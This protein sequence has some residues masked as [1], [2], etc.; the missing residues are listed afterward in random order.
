MGKRKER[1][2]AA[3][4][5]AGRRVKLDLCAEPPDLSGS[6]AHEEVGED[7]NAKLDTGSPKSP[8]SSGQEP[9]NPLLLLGQYSDEELDE[10]SSEGPVD[11]ERFVADKSIQ[12]KEHEEVTTSTVE[13]PPS[14]KVTEQDGGRVSCSGSPQVVEDIVEGENNAATAADIDQEINLG[15]SIPMA[16]DSQIFGDAISCWKMVM[17]QESNQ[18]YYWNTLT[19]ETSWEVPIALAQVPL[20]TGTQETSLAEGKDSTVVFGVKPD[21]VADEHGAQID[22]SVEGYEGDRNEFVNG[23]CFGWRIASGN[24]QTWELLIIQASC[25]HCGQRG[26]VQHVLLL[27][28]L[29]MEQ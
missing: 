26:G 24:F 7:L 20:L 23:F 16:S 15:K 1:R 22:Q 13:D 27:R 2:L 17:H 6:S 3:M 12:S 14:V 9:A 5:G 19:G 21:G 25:E 4:M 29:Y 11:Q 8:S 10:V 18:Y 28:W